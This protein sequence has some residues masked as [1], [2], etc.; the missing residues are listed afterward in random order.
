[1]E[2]LPVRS[3]VVL[4][5]DEL[6]VAFSRGGGPGGQNVNKVE[7]RV[8]LR[9]NP[10]SSRALDERQR[11]RVLTAWEGKLTDAGDFLIRAGEHREQARNLEAALA[12]LVTQLRAALTIPKQR[13][14][15]KP[16]KG[17]HR[18]RLGE[19]KSRGDIKKGRQGEW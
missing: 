6:R 10:A 1:V 7:S 15:T 2:P 13:R 5:A 8:E 4:P 18:R 17:S 12:R 16:T 9:W 3:G 14:A 11:E 19:K